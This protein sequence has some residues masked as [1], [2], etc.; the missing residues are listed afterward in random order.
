MRPED[1]NQNQPPNQFDAPNNP[2]N[3]NYNQNLGSENP[4][5]IEYLNSIAPKK[6]PSFWTKGKIFLVAFIA[7]GLVLSLVIFLMPNNR[8]TDSQAITKFYYNLL[9]LENIAKNNQKR[10]KNSDL[11]SVNA[12]IS[13]SIASN[14]TTFSNYMTSRSITILEGSKLEK[15]TNYIAVNRDYEKIIN[16]LDE[17]FL[18]TTLDDVYKREMSYQLSVVK[19]MANKLDA[20]LKTTKSSEALKPIIENLE[21]SINSLNKVTG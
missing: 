16:T 13:T 4:Y 5:S 21:N 15:D 8:T 10:L 18:K 1:Y 19:D 9:Q 3:P 14:K 20:R 12:S 7:I 17:A 2:P 6:A 11:A